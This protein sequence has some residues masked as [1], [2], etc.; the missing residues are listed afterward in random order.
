MLAKVFQKLLAKLSN[1]LRK[2]GKY[3]ERSK[4]ERNIMLTKNEITNWPVEQLMKWIE[5]P[6]NQLEIYHLLFGDNYNMVR[7]RWGIFHELSNP[8][9]FKAMINCPAAE[10]EAY[11][12]TQKNG[13]VALQKALHTILENGEP[14]HDP[15]HRGRDGYRIAYLLSDPTVLKMQTI[16]QIA[17]VIGALYHDVATGI[18]HRY[19]DKKIAGHGE[20]GAA[21]VYIVLMEMGYPI[22]AK[23]SAYGIAAHTHYTADQHYVTPEFEPSLALRRHFYN[24]ELWEENG[25][26]YGGSVVLPRLAD[27]GSMGIMMA[28]RHMMANILAVLVDGATDVLG[29]TTEAVKLDANNAIAILTPSMDSDLGKT[30]IKH[31]T[32]FLMSRHPSIGGGGVNTWN[33]YD[34]QFP[35]FQELLLHN[36]EIWDRVL[37]ALEA[38][39]PSTDNVDREEV[40]TAMATLLARVN[41]GPRAV[42]A[43]DVIK[44]FWDQIPVSDVKIWAALV[45]LMSDLYDESLQYMREAGY[46]AAENH[47]LGESLKSVLA[48]ID[49]QLL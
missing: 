6:Y 46:A 18:V 11:L 24:F 33:Q 40:W 12:F 36:K 29:N 27:R 1:F 39:E 28:L 38:Y 37:V 5:D 2:V 44:T 47:P 35:K 8:F 20:V 15:G 7:T 4:G 17:A 9:M 41:V 48:E 49:S 30:T 42:E 25:V 16:E 31:I 19:L 23:L 13:L 26:V 21:L 32:G 43:A 34:P 14:G 10:V 3:F 45:P 22:L